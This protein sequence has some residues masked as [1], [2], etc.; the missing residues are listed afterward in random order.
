M[1]ADT[2]SLQD[3]SFQALYQSDLQSLWALLVAPVAFLAWRAARPTDPTRARV[4][5]A[6][7][8]V[9]SLTLCFAVLTM[10]DPICTG[11]VAD[12]ALFQSTR[13]PLL[14]MFF[15]VLLGDFRVLFLAISVARPEQARTR[16]LG[17]ASAVTLI[18][19]V[20]TGLVYGTLDRLIEHLH[21][22]WLWMIYEAGFALLCIGLSRRWLPR[23][24]AGASGAEARID[25]LRDVFA[26]STAY[27]V[28]WLSADALIVLGDLDLGWALRVV[29]NQLYYA[30]WVPFVYARFY[31]ASPGPWSTGPVRPS[32]NASR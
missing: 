26:Y 31:S 10:I 14:I 18:V 25:Y 17:W 29:P 32:E 8:S 2:L 4:P 15:F 22:Q 20:A 23:S 5:E 7:R 21:G 9:A 11:P 12:L 27:Y 13:V 1:N 3:Y 24:L 19:P 16:R 30:F 28:L 6:S